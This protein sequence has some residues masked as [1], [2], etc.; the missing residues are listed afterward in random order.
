MF[1]LRDKNPVNIRSLSEFAQ[2]RTGKLM[3]IYPFNPSDVQEAS[4]NW[5]LRLL[6]AALIFLR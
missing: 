4:N 2:F 6:V 3:H 1:V 5:N